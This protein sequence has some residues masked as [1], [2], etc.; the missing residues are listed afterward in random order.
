LGPHLSRLHPALLTSIRPS[1]KDL[2]GTNTLA[3]NA[4]SSITEEIFYNIE[5]RGKVLNFFIRNLRI[6]VISYSVC[7]WQA[8]LN[9]MFAGE[10]GAYF[11]ALPANIR[12][13]WKGLPGT[14]TLA[15]YEHS[16]IAEAN[17]FI[18]LRP[19]PNIIKLF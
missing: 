16:S 11:Q 5:T 1:C 17:S 19:G 8:Q 12:L 3:Y 7:P 14:N 13:G 9:L 18:T 6:F 15:F 10:A 2:P 4:K